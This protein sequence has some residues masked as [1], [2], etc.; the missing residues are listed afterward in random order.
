MRTT[1]TVGMSESGLKI[2]E[3]QR[4]ENLRIVPAA[5][6]AVRPAELCDEVSADLLVGLSVISGMPRLVV[7]LVAISLLVEVINV[8]LGEVE[9]ILENSERVGEPGGVGVSVVTGELCC[10]GR[11]TVITPEP[12]ISVVMRSTGGGN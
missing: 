12:G 7:A 11:S 3:T 2:W 6:P 4:W 5:I 1:P 10:G 8:V 9:G